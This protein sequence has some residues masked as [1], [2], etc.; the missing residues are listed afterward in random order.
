MMEYIDGMTLNEFLATNPTTQQRQKVVLQPIVGTIEALLKE[1]TVKNYGNFC[2][3]K[4]CA[5][6]AM[7][8]CERCLQPSESK[9]YYS[10]IGYWGC[11][12][13]VFGKDLHN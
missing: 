7:A 5:V 8:T 10:R 4:Y 3:Y 9:K 11:G 6:F 12:K 13:C 1:D 2:E